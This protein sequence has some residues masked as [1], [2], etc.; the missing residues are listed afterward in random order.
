MKLNLMDLLLPM[1]YALDM[2]EH[3]LTGATGGHGE[4]VALLT[5]LMARPLHYPQ[6][7]LMD[8]VECALLHDCGA[9]ENI[10]NLRDA[11]AAGREYAETLPDGTVVRDAN[12]HAIL[13]EKDIRPLPFHGDVRNIVLMHHECVDGSGP[14]GRKEDEIPFPSQLIFLA[15]RM[16]IWFDLQTLPERG[17]QPMIDSLLSRVGREFSRRAADLMVQNI[18]YD[19]IRRIQE[20]GAKALLRELLPQDVT[21]YS[22]PQIYALTRFFEHIVDAKSSF[23]KDHSAGIADKAERM[24]GFYGWSVD[25]TDRFLLAAALHD[26]GKLTVET[27]I[28]EKP[29]K[30][31]PEEFT[32]IQRHVRQTYEILN[33]IPGFED[34][35]DWASFHHEKLDGSGYCF[36]LTAERLSFESRLMACID[37]YQALTEKRP[38]KDGFSHGKAMD[39]M[40]EMAAAGK[41]DGAIVQDLDKVFGK[42]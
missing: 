1:I 3:D 6:P 34:I 26:Y 17:F 39:I 14:L 7:Q 24:A 41:I 19:D 2:E 16:D 18:H 32:A 5:Y 23:T 10:R 42:Q 25:K 15:D 33:E 30:L 13:G 38:Y 35:R 40:Q 37:I 36:G 22:R 8:I 9:V 21:D 20:K 28:L 27:D 31:T 12:I 11:R 4:R 29:D